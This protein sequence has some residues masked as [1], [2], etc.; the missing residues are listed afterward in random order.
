MKGCWFE[1]RASAHEAPLERQ[2]GGKRDGGRRQTYESFSLS[3]FVL[4]SICLSICL[5]VH[6]LL[7]PSSASPWLSWQTHISTSYKTEEQMWWKSRA[8]TTSLFCFLKNN[9]G[10]FNSRTA[11]VT[12]PSLFD[13][14]VTQQKFGPNTKKEVITIWIIVHI[15]GFFGHFSAAETSYNRHIIITLKWNMDR[16]KGPLKDFHFV[17]IVAASV[18]KSSTAYCRKDLV[19]HEHLSERNTPL[20]SSIPVPS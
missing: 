15:N 11:E 14:G 10:C 19:Q 6:S 8:E 1:W 16:F 18:D 9:Q 5:S 12:N 3:L 20:I 13:L 4:T 7:P 17:S 2:E